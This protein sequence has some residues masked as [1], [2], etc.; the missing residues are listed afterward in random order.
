VPTAIARATGESRRYALDCV[1]V[2]PTRCGV[3]LQAS[4]GRQAVCVFTQGHVSD[5]AL[6][7]SK[8]LPVQAR[9][10]PASVEIHRGHWRAR[11]GSPVPAP[12]GGF[13][14]IADVL[15]A[16]DARFVT[17]SLDVDQLKKVA[18]VLGT[19]KLTLML[20]PG[21]RHNVEK[22]VAVM[23]AER[24]DPTYRGGTS[25]TPGA[26][27]TPEASGV[28]GLGVVLPL[29]TNVVIEDYARARDAVLQAEKRA[30]V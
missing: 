20:Q 22:P 8:L 25:A 12:A 23:P 1:R 15:P 13:P 2:L 29:I 6:L 21:D 7:P 10:L 24:G 17:V 16:V 5:S 26:T 28:D 18:A 3:L 9:H 19:A 4:D 14:P 11:D 30:R 27:G